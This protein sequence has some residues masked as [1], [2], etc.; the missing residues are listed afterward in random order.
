MEQ[1]EKL[2][3]KSIHNF[4]M[5][6]MASNDCDAQKKFKNQLIQLQ[7]NNQSRT[8]PEEE[9]K[10]E[11]TS[12]VHQQS[13][14]SKIEE[15]NSQD[16][17]DEDRGKEELVFN[18]A[19]S[20]NISSTYNNPIKNQYIEII[21][22]STRS[23]NSI[24]S[25]NLSMN[26]K[27][28][29][30]VDICEILPTSI[31]TN[32]VNSLDNSTKKI[33][34]ETN[35]N[36]LNNDQRSQVNSDYSK[37]SLIS[38]TIVNQDNKTIETASAFKIKASNDY[39]PTNHPSVFIRGS[40]LSVADLDLIIQELIII[41]QNRQEY[42]QCR[43]W[44][45]LT[46]IERPLRDSSKQIQK[47]NTDN[48]LSKQKDINIDDNYISQEVCLSRIG[49]NIKKSSQNLNN[50][51][52]FYSQYFHSVLNNKKSNDIMTELDKKVDD[53]FEFIKKKNT[54][55]TD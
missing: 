28:L 53:F 21:S 26:T 41:N 31:S 8:I 44:H 49:F 17:D 10:D 32:G 46:D 4:L 34:D 37:A 5:K 35:R 19:L 42:D 11:K 47:T 27:D 23:M 22:N 38:Q 45:Y 48:Q 15:G 51:E 18:S 2:L 20:R 16:Y 50:P 13:Q 24:C 6:N 29:H 55:K 25:E 54:K 43:P 39:Y 12:I 36:E 1:I 33:T 7:C 40:K 9:L 14:L 30:Y 52:S 3:N